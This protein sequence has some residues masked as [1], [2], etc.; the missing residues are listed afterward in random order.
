MVSL[1]R[2]YPSI[3][4]W[5]W[6]PSHRSSFWCDV[7]FCSCVFLYR[8][9]LP[10]V[11]QCLGALSTFPSP[12]T[13]LFLSQALPN[14]KCSQ[15]PSCNLVWSANLTAVFFLWWGGR[16]PCREPQI[17]VTASSG[18]VTW[19]KL[20]SNTFPIAVESHYSQWLCSI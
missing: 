4:V 2:L 10:F 6:I 1:N 9:K 12:L 17:L 14:A 5:T 8:L 11:N 15:C 19:G 16:S 18:I 13:S 20:Q 7:Y 3:A